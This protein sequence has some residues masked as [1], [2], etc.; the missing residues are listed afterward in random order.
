MKKTLIALIT[1][2]AFQFSI[3]QSEETAPTE[4]EMVAE[5]NAK[6][7]SIAAIQ[8]RV[9]AIQAKIDA[10]PGWKA[11]AFG[12]VGFNLS[13]FTNWYTQAIPNNTSGNIGFTFNTFA[14]LKQE[15]YFWRNNM[16]VNLGW[17]RLDD[18]DNEIDEKFEV[19]TDVF[20]L[21]SLFGWNITKSLAVSSLAEYRTTL[22]NDFNNPG[23]LD[24][25]LGGTWTPIQDLVVVVHPLNY[26]I[27]FTDEENI[28]ESSLGAKIVADY[29]RN[30]GQ[31][32]FKS[33]LSSFLSYA[34][35]NLNNV[36]WTNGFSYTLWKSFGIGFDFALRSN[37]Q[38]ALDFTRNVLAVENPELIDE[39]LDSVDNELQTFWM[40][41]VS[42]SF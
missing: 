4:E 6:K 24:I 17:V 13:N 28:Y 27:I 32:G 41:G 26:N 33:N 38:E 14:N 3:A 40:L 36:T 25:G 29:T 23:Y 20:Q 35:S 16:S 8:K 5:M 10:L 21:T 7:D 9:N 37:R 11:G 15:N 42:Y 30:I 12:T 18:R 39:T 34:D 19:T 1:L 2:I 22:L 31:V